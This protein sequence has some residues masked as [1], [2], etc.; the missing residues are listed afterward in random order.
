[1][2]ELKL[3]INGSA[4]D[5]EMHLLE[6]RWVCPSVGGFLSM[7]GFFFVEMIRFLV[8]VTREPHIRHHRFL[9]DIENSRNN[10][11]IIIINFPTV[12]SEDAESHIRDS[13]RV[14]CTTILRRSIVNLKRN[15]TYTHHHFR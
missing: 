6:I 5:S 11:N 12:T 10:N 1:M 13:L 2:V 3:N 4:A 9:D 15:S 7:E 14:F 8:E